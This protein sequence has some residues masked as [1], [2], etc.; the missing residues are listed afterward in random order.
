MRDE[1][2]TAALARPR[3]A[4][5]RAG[6]ATARAAFALD[7]AFDA[8]PG[9][10]VLFGPSGA[11]KST[12]LAA[13][14][15][16]RAARR[17]GASPLGDETW[18]DAERGDRRRPCIERRVAFVFQS[19]A[20]FPHMTALEN[21]AYG[22]AASLDRGGARGARA[23]RCSSGCASRTSPI[24]RRRRSPAARRS[25]SPSRARSR[26]SRASSCSTSRSARSTAELRRELAADV[27]EILRELAVP[28]RLRDPSARGGARPR[29]PA[30]DARPR[31]H[32]GVSSVA[33]AASGPHGTTRARLRER[34][35]RPRT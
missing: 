22:M 7:V 20:L 27:R 16:P 13:I 1:R 21:V 6:R 25:A 2:A 9:V 15:G 35:S 14:A 24:A 3:R 12:T 8:P 11:G 31:T 32:H 28:V 30:G 10:T 33:P 19:L 29:R 18:F 34:R 5:T 23:R 26:R 17:A 4:A